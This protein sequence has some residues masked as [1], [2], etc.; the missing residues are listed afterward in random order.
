VPIE[1]GRKVSQSY[2][3][4]VRENILPLSVANTLP[5]AFGEWYFTENTIDHE[6]AIEDCQ[7]CDQEKLRYHFQI[8]NE[9]TNKVLWVGSQ[10]ILKFQIAVYDDYRHTLD[11]KGAKK[12][13]NKLLEAIRV[14]SCIKALNTV[15]TKTKNKILISALDYYKKNK[16]LTPKFAFVVFWQLQKN[17]IDRSPSFFKISLRKQVYKDDLEEMPTE[18]VHFFWKALTPAQ[19]NIAIDLG[20]EPPNST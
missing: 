17:R 14:K 9:Y 18:R 15:A 5:E 20:H 8:E 19:R 16:F 3:K 13:L 10:C 6:E 7:L 4:R 2:S 1:R 11:E 12:K